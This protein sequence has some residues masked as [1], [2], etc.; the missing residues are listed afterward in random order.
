MTE[1]LQVLT[2]VEDV[3]FF[4]VQP[5]PE[6][7]ETETGAAPQHLPEFGLGANQLEEDQVH[8]LRHVDAGIQHI[9]GDGDV[10][11]PLLLVKFIDDTLHVLG[12][13][14][15]DPGE[16]PL[17]VGII[18]IEPLVDKLGMGL[19]FGKDDG[20]SQS[21]SAGN[22]QAAG[23]DVLQ[24]LVHGVRIE[25]PF[26]DRLRLHPV[27]SV[28]LLVPLHGIPLVLFLVGKGVIADP[29]PLEFQRDRDRPGGN[30]EFVGHRFVQ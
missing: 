21:I 10:G 9:H 28:P 7:T 24:H 8:H 13:K 11:S 5:R 18:Q 12:L 16:L 25:E 6:Q 4:L 14:G 30:Q 3:K 22:L 17:V 15:N 20:L 2:E 29:L 1:V 23:H 27:G 19:I 26:I